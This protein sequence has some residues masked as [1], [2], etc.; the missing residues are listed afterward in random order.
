MS[1]LTNYDFDDNDDYND[2]DN[3]DDD[4]DDD[5]WLAFDPGVK[6]TSS[7]NDLLYITVVV[8]M[9]M[10]QIKNYM[11]I[12]YRRLSSKLDFFLWTSLQFI[13]LIK[14]HKQCVLKQKIYFPLSLKWAI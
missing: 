2:D 5:D 11:W 7:A 4:N 9:F 12:N 6:L 10:V 8:Q 14:V 3:D 13:F 1:S